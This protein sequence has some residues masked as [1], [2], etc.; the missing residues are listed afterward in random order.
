MLDHR[1][2][3]ADDVAIRLMYRLH[4]SGLPPGIAERDPTGYAASSST[5]CYSWV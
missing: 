3:A 1:R 4:R 5:L 2:P